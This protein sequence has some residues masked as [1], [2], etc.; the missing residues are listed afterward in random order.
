MRKIILSFCL[1]FICYCGYAQW[2]TLSSGSTNDLRSV[3]FTDVN[4]GFAVGDYGTIVKTS[5]GGTTWIITSV[6]TNIQLHSVFF[7]N[8]NTGYA[9]GG[10]ASNSG[11]IYKTSDAGINWTIVANNISEVFRSVY[12]PNADTG[13]AVGVNGSI[14][15]TLNAGSQWTTLQSGININL[16]SAYF[17]NTNKG[18]VTG[19]NGTILNTINGGTNWISMM[20]GTYNHLHSVYFP[21]VNNGIAVG[22]Q[23]TILTTLDGGS[24][25]NVLV[26]N[27]P[28]KNLNSIHAIHT[29]AHNYAYI[30][31]QSGIFIKCNDNYI[32]N[33][34]FIPGIAQTLN[35]VYFIN[36][37]VGYTVGDYGTILKTTNGGGVSV[38]MNDSKGE[39]SNVNIYPNPASDH[40]TIEAPILSISSRLSLYSL[41]G[42]KLLNQETSEPVTTIDISSFPDG[43]YFLAIEC[44]ERP[45]YKIFIKHG[46]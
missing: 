33:H 32:W 20:S 11:I 29:T 30:V 42:I 35:S 38:G 46:N 36:K 24:S 9:V 21:D 5:D 37:D 26:L 17:F 14:M 41:Q 18:F 31:G 1:T 40:L 13:F 6:G 43:V 16:S 34:Y 12:F 10:N 22:N 19:D 28:Q 44:Q 2:T 27:I 45:F 4:H 7:T 3:Y 8:A 23:G 39:N 15:K 25:W